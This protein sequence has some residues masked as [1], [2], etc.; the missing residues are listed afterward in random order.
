LNPVLFILG[1]VIIAGAV[2]AMTMR[3]LI[4]SVLSLAVSFVGVAMLFLR[5]DAE[6][7]GFAQILV[8]V[9][10]VAILIVF[11]VLLTRVGGVDP[12]QFFHARWYVG[13]AIAVV[14]FG[15][16]ATAILNTAAFQRDALVEKG[17]SVKEIGITLMTHHVLPLEVMGLLLTAAMLG[18]VIV[19]LQEGGRE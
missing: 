5:L 3:N 13:L 1:V 2:A 16:L 17:A 18:A 8:Y 14:V 10:A 6:F 11:A 19:A 12:R 9:G 7:V 4:H 15:C